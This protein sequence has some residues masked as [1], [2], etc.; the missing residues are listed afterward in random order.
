MS[1]IPIFGD[2]DLA[3]YQEEVRERWGDTD[4]YRESARRTARYTDED[5]KQIG[6]EGS[7]INE[8]FM[9]L[10]RAGTPPDGYEAIRLAER[11]RAH[12]SRWFYECTPEIHAGLG[13]MY[14]AD[15]RFRENIDRA[16]PGPAQYM[17]EAIA[18]SSGR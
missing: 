17:S 8:A 10:M 11:H 1:E 7:E 12:I 15:Q 2:F 3:D 16:A 6:R 13:E 5:R 9:A 14:V 18:A 4:A